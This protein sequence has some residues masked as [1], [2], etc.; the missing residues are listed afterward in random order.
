MRA[1]AVVLAAPSR[2]GL[3]TFG[4]VLERARVGPLTDAG[5]D[6]ALGL[7]VGGWRIGTGA[8]VADLM[9]GARLGEGLAALEHFQ[10]DWKHHDGSSGAMY[11]SMGE[12]QCFGGK[13]VFPVTMKPL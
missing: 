12:S 5:L 13:P 7:A 9:G 2:H 11:G 10:P 1:F 8:L 6:G 3:A 4:G